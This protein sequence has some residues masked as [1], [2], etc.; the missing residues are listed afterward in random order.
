[1]KKKL[2]LGLSSISLMTPFVLLSSSCGSGVKPKMDPKDDPKNNNPINKSDFDNLVKSINQDDVEFKFQTIRYH[3][4]SELYA[5]DFQDLSSEI[6]VNAISDKIKDKVNLS[7]I[8]AILSS[9]EDANSKGEVEIVLKVTS[10][11]GKL[12]ATHRIKLT[13]LKKSN[14]GADRQ[15]RFEIKNKLKPDESKT[16]EYLKS[17]TQDQRFETDNESYVNALKENLKLNGQTGKVRNELSSTSDEQ[18]KKFDEIAKTK[19]F[20]TYEN[21]SAKGFTL[22]TYKGNDY[23]GLSMFEG[24]EI[25]KQPSWVDTGNGNRWQVKGLARTLPNEMYKKA[26]LQTFQ[27]KLTNLLQG[28]DSISESGTMWIL[29]YQKP[30]N[31][32]YPTKFYFGTNLHVADHLTDKTI[33]VSMLRLEKSAGIKTTYKLSEFDTSVFKRFTFASTLKNN[34]ETPQPVKGFKKVFDGR[35][36]LTKKPADYLNETQKAKYANFEEYVDFAV[37]EM[38]F[39]E[40]L[41]NKFINGFSNAEELAKTVTNDYHSDTANHIKFLQKSYLSDYSKINV[42]LFVD[43]SKNETYKKF[44]TYDQLFAVGYPLSVE[45][46]FLLKDQYANEAQ[47]KEM[48]WNYSLW[49]NSD[50]RYYENLAVKEGAQ[51]TF[52]EDQLKLGNFLS[53]QIGYRTFNDKPG[54]VDTFLSVPKVG[55]EFHKSSDGKQYIK[56]GLAYLPKRFAPY[57]GSSGSSIRNQRNEMVGVFYASNTF[58]NTGLAD[59]FRC[60]GYDYGDM[61]GT[62]DK[63]YSLPQY[64]L[65]Y[66]LG[67][68]QKNSYRQALEKLYKNQGITTA[69]FANG[70]SDEHVPS[71]FKF[72]Q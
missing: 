72:Q 27:V 20:D 4:K 60:E 58:A 41:D 3:D 59:A 7:Y 40:L 21:A 34:N 8:N 65:I 46:F 52:S 35:D 63:K 19:K 1:M 32:E 64:D 62:G 11:D 71:E 55:K 53:Y 39:K 9:R 38:D 10:K 18:I 22:P 67:K 24:N 28:K 16:E 23:D 25:G 30:K 37:F 6:S 36:F 70:L 44:E 26:A 33:G 48:K 31:G 15:G 14:F 57:G 61:F 2:I 17:Y 29:D 42:P 13:G 68:D 51:P 12:E 47:I 69:L 50:Y 54:L 45:D 66:G 56:F 5:T 43:T 49:I